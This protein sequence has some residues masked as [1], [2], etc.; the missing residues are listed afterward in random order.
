MTEYELLRQWEAF[1]AAQG[2]AEVT[3][4][5]YRYYLHRLASEVSPP[6]P[7]TRIT[8]QDVVV[9]L[10]TLSDKASARQFSMMAFRSFFRWA[11]ERGHMA[12]DPSEHL[13]PKG[14]TERPA[15]AFTPEEV[16]ALMVAARTYRANGERD[17]LAIQLCYAM[18]LR[19]TEL[20][21]ITPDDIDWGGRR[22]L[23]RHAKGDQ[24]RWVESNELAMEALEGLRPWWNGTVLGS[25]APQWFTMIVH[26]AAKRAGLP[27]G[28][29]NAH[30]LR[31]AF[32]T[33]LLEE[34]VPI[35]VV[36][37]LLGHAKIQTTARY[38]AC[39][40]KDRR[41]AVARLRIPS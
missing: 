14:P 9:F 29:R 6:K 32:A 35:S 1:M 40:D 4:R 26:R 38:L 10:A 22:V 8:E 27:P 16:G 41:D 30:K 3:V 39:R 11:H 24:Q 2:R 19:R 15:D 34:G 18:G 5:K 33:S 23:I 13:H 21:G 31:S 17:A 25:V 20:C 37:R 36:S 28:R 12:S 7:L